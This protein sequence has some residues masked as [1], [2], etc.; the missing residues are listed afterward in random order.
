MPH[1]T[2]PPRTLPGTN[3][4]PGELLRLIAE[5]VG[6][7]PAGRNIFLRRAR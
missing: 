1:P 7:W 6:Q 4:T 5:I 3:L 2:T